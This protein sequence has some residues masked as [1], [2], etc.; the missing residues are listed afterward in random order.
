LPFGGT[1]K[2]GHGREKGFAALREFGTT[3][4]VM[5]DD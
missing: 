2:S 5:K 4:A 3:K 1:G